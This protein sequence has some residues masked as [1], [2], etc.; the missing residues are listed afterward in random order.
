MARTIH[1]I[2]AMGVAAAGAAAA[3]DIGIGVRE[4]VNSCAQCHGASG[5]GDGYLAG[6]LNKPAPD[7]TTL[8]TR[9]GGVFPVSAVYGLIDGTGPTGIHGGGDMPAWG[10]R[11]RIDA[12]NQLGIEFTSEDREVFVRARILGLIEYVAS[13]Q[14]Q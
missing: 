6:F 7:L 4:Y 2:A 14:A 1:L 9:N 12:A 11:Y 3:Q 10:D 8:Q 5:V 13:I